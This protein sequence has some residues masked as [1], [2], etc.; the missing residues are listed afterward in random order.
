MYLYTF[1]V[2]ADEYRG[3]EPLKNSSSDKGTLYPSLNSV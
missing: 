2:P 3:S 1:T